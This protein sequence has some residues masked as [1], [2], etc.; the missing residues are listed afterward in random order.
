MSVTT[1]APEAVAGIRA[2]HD[3]LE[4]QAARLTATGDP[5]ASTVAAYAAA[6]GA[7]HSLIVD[8]NL[9]AAAQHEAT[10][11]LIQEARKPWS[12]DEMRTLITEL[13]RT[14]LHRWTQFNRAGI[15]I[16]VV[17]AL[18]FG[19]ACGVGGCGGGVPCPSSSAFA[20]GRIDAKTGRT[21]AGCAGYPSMSDCHPVDPYPAL[22]REDFHPRLQLLTFRRPRA[23]SAPSP[24]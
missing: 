19:V 7:Q 2:A 4:Q 3:A 22:G 14:L 16:G 6:V 20:L 13:D 1:L 8:A 10:A 18:V 9:T 21:E 15:A 23:T 11:Q 17:V 12:R 5:V 24:P